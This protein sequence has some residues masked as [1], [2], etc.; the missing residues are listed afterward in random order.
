MIDSLLSHGVWHT[1][2]LRLHLDALA[3]LNQRAPDAAVPN[4]L[5]SMCASIGVLE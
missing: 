1:D 2:A 5:R 4:R 3:P